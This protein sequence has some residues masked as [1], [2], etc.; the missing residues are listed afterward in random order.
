MTH[1]AARYTDLL[2]ENCSQ[3]L[4]QLDQSYRVLQS[5][6][7]AATS[8]GA[9]KPEDLIGLALRAAEGEDGIRLDPRF[10]SSDVG[11]PIDG[12]YSAS[13]PFGAEL[14]VEIVFLPLP[15]P[16]DAGAC[17]LALITDLTVRVNG[18]GLEFLRM[19]M[20]LLTKHL[21]TPKKQENS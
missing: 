11:D 1:W 9:R 10:V 5:N 7:R 13:T 6:R 2:V 3:G 12:T 4:L 16:D 21:K 17:W 14:P 19:I 8:F 15:E 18:T 20:I